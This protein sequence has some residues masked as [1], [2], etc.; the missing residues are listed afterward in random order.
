MSGGTF[1]YVACSEILVEEFDRGKRQFL[2]MIFVL[3]G[4]AVVS[5]VWFIGHSHAHGHGHDHG[6][7][8]HAHL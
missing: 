7:H 2:Q 1:V 5:A 8:G 6:G 3:I 4:C